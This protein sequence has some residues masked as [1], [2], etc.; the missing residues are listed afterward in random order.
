MSAA[1]WSETVEEVRW[2]WLPYLCVC[3]RA[4]AWNAERA[5]CSRRIRYLALLYLH[6]VLGGE[7]YLFGCRWI[8]LDAAFHHAR[9]IGVKG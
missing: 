4:R 9:S 7:E 1:V 2:G 8:G 3:V 6:G 5:C